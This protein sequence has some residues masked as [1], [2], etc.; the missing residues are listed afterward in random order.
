MMLWLAF[1]VIAVAATVM[2]CF[3]LWR[4]RIPTAIDV[5]N[6]VMDVPNTNQPLYSIEKISKAT[7][8]LWLLGLPLC[9]L[10]VYWVTQEVAPVQRWIALQT[11]MN[12][13]MDQLVAGKPIDHQQLSALKTDDLVM[14]LQHR[15]QQKNAAAPAWLLLGRIYESLNDGDQAESAYRK[16]ET[17]SLNEW[18]PGLNLL[19][20]KLKRN[21]GRLDASDT[22]LIQ[23]LLKKFPTTRRLLA[24]YAMTA[25]QNAQYSAALNV[26]QQLLRATDPKNTSAIA[27]LT[28]SIGFAQQKMQAQ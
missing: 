23:R 21:Q 26:W 28:R 17:Q 14:V 13:L 25:Y 15:L 5:S 20:F 24:F 22:F 11:Q 4:A 12:P 19:L 10:G 2:V 27:L 9:L 8:F 18:E 6:I 1:S 16:A 7:Q 3:P